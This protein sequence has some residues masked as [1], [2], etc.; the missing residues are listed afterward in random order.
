MVMPDIKETVS[1]PEGVEVQIEGN[2]VSV[3]GEKGENSR[4]LV[5]PKM[6]IKKEENK[7]VLEFKKPTKREKRM[8]NTFKAHIKN[9]MKGVKEGFLYKLKICSSHFPMSVKVEGNQVVISNFLGEKI[10]RKAGIVEGVNVKIEGDEILVEGVDKEKVSL[11]AGRI[12]QA[13]R[14]TNRSRIVFQ[15]GCFITS[16]DGKEIR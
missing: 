7:V 6:I 13:T 3:K 15:D 4:K 16:K 9:L 12:E 11:T 10:P 8:A 2:I 14:I 5:Y 1:I